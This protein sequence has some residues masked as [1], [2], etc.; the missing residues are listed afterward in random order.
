MRKP[1]KMYNLL[2]RKNTDTPCAKEYDFI[3][4]IKGNS[5][6]LI[7]SKGDLVLIKKQSYIDDNPNSVY[8]IRMEKIH[9]H[10]CNV[11]IIDNT[12]TMKMIGPKN[13]TMSTSFN[14]G[15]T[16]P[17]IIGKVVDYFKLSEECI[18]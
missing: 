15:F 7:L 3:Y 10:I 9:T 2:E 11:T 1:T 18:R 12:I 6:Y 4:E 13:S 14:K 8:L 17:E 5:G 16:D